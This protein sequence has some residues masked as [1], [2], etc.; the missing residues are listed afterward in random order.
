MQCS[1]FDAYDR[2]AAAGNVVL[3]V[4][5]DDDSKIHQTITALEAHDPVELDER[6]DE[7]NEGTTTSSTAPLTGAST[8]G[9]DFSSSEVAQARATNTT[10]PTGRGGVSDAPGQPV[11]S[12]TTLLTKRPNRC[13]TTDL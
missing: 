2:T 7:V 8:V 12:G 10:I 11:G 9:R 1:A 3:S 5:V 13:C 6:S 4:T